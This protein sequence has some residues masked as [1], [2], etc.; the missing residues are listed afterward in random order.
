[1][2]ARKMSA[3]PATVS[4]AARLYAAA[5]VVL[6]RSIRARY[7]RDMQAT[8]AARAAD[9]SRGGRGRGALA[10]VALLALEL[11]DVAAVSLRRRHAAASTRPH[12]RRNQNVPSLMNDV[13]YALR[14]LRR[15]PGFAAVAVITLALGIGATTAVFTV[16]D[17]VL[18]RPL[19]YRDPDRLV[20]L[21]HGRNGHLSASYSPPNYRDVTTQSG[22]FSGAAALTT[23]TATVTG[24]G[25]PQQIDGG[26]VTTTFF[27]VL[28]VTPRHGRGLVEADGADGAPPV[29]VIGEGLWRRLYGARP[30]AVGSTIRMDGKLFTIVGVAPA[31]LR[32]PGGAEYWRPLML[33]ARDLSD[34]ARGA[35]YVGVVARLKPGIDL[36]QA[37]SAMAVVAERLSRDYPRTN[38]DRVMTAMPLHERIVRGVRPALLILLGS[39]SLVL[40][41]ACVNV[42]NLLLARA[43]GRTREV[44]VRAALGA[45]RRRLVQQFLA[46]SVVLGVLGGAGGLAVAWWSTRALVALGPVSIP[47]LSEIA[48]DWRVLAFTVAI[49]VG[50]SVAFGFVPALAATGGAVARLI[51]SAGRGAIGHGT[52]VRKTLVVCEMALAVMLLVGAGLLIRSYDR[53]ASVDPGFAPD[54][55]LTFAMAL[56][57]QGYK[58]TAATERFFDDLIGRLRAR[59][60]VEAAAGIYGLP[61][62][63]NFAAYS[64]FTRR[65]E[66]DSADAPTAGMRIVTADYFSTLRIP[67]RAGRLFTQADT[68]TAPEVAVINEEAARRFW[69]GKNPI[70]EQIHLGVRLAEARSGQKTIV[71]IVADVKFGGLDAAAPPEV[72][73]PYAQHPVDSLTIAVRTAGE[74]RA[75]IPIARSDVAAIDRDLAVAA[76]RTMD[77]VVGRSI[78]ERRFTMLL[79]ASFAVVAVLLAAIGVYGVL[80]YLVSQRTQ[81]IGVRLAIGASPRDVVRLFLREGATLALV[82]LAAGLAGALAAARVMTVL[83]FGVTTSDPLTF[84][85][86]AAAL[87]VVALLASYLPARRAARV[88]PMTALRDH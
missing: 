60:G 79:L 69:P 83:L 6:P 16:V 68:D 10:V 25:D 8:F 38:K 11:A 7:A 74:P 21:L 87:G 65:G 76:V 70:G 4:A 50:T 71:G 24:L 23:S 19:P 63:D 58:T 77:E 15:Q 72:Y 22:A 45:G 1:M 5:L 67:L 34:Q 54:H 29:V 51:S 88:D 57:G 84:A 17:G 75:F 2:V 49:A 27:S 81:E 82:G 12:D 86:V 35:Q 32:M 39:V 14:L 59:P 55:I 53:I 73:V 43:N 47:R 64:S 40:L 36:E 46:E 26:D 20:L 28:G 13:R 80:A 31:D 78:A 18:L 62:D 37:K 85:S 3:A 41:V 30:D 66:A 56:P 9:A 44:A 42:A 61:L 48:V 52:R 33:S